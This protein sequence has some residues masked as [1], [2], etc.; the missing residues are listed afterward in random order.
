MR[1]ASWNVNG[2]RAAT[3]NGFLNWFEDIEADLICIQ[4]S[5]AQ[6][7]QLDEEI[8]HPK[9]YESIWHSAEKKG[10][11][12]VAIYSKNEPKEVHVGL[13]EDKFDSEGRVLTVEYGD[14]TL[15]TSY[16]P[17]SQRDHARLPYKLDF[18]ESIHSYLN[19]LREAGQNVLVCGDFNISH[20]EIDLKNP[21]TNKKNAGFLPE[22][23]AWMDVFTE[24]GW[25]DT[26]RMFEPGG[27]HYTWWSYR[28]GIRDRNIGWRLDY[29]VANSE[30]TDRIEKSY[31]QPQVLGSDHCPVIIDIKD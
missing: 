14:L 4:E 27:D 18:C 1:V 10:Y 28:P 17:N 26:F 22:E 19:S 8:L 9:G 21:K 3:R 29:F 23:R 7:D 20:K 16:F 5:K 24:D 6:K 31:H 12:G 25:V 11:S 13:G 30:W 2:I 15:V